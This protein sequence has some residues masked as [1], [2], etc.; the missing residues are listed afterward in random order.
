MHRPDS[1]IGYGGLSPL[2]FRKGAADWSI[3]RRESF[4]V[5]TSHVG[6]LM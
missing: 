1:T 3:N 6:P 4:L 5:L 2:V